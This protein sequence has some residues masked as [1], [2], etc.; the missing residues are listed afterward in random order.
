[1][2]AWGTGVFDN[3]TACDWA[4]GLEEQG[5]LALIERTLDTVLAA[6]GEYLDASDAEEALAA[7]ETIA[8]LQGH[9]GVRNSYTANVDAWVEKVKLQPSATLALKAHAAIDRILGADSEILELWDD[10]ERLDD[11]KRDVDDLRMRVH[12]T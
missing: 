5:D 12:L 11:W 9:W 7:I 8:R 2:G 3:D 10:S 6:G 1:M 4:Y